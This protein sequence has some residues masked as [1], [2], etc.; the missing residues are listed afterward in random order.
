MDPLERE[1]LAQKAWIRQCEDLAALLDRMA[2]YREDLRL[3]TRSGNPLLQVRA[4]DLL[5]LAEDRLVELKATRIVAAQRE[6]AAARRSAEA[7]EQAKRVEVERAQEELRRREAEANA[8]AAA[9]AEARRQEEDRLA[10]VRQAREHRLAEE[11]ARRQEEARAA[12]EAEQHAATRLANARAA[13]V[14]ARAVLLRAKAAQIANS[15]E[16]G[17]VGVVAG[18]RLP[19]GQVA[20]VQ[21]MPNA[22]APARTEMRAAPS[23]PPSRSIQLAFAPPSWKPGPTTRSRIGAKRS[24]SW[25]NASPSQ[26]AA[27]TSTIASSTGRSHFT[28]LTPQAPRTGSE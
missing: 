13:E 2:C 24:T 18:M 23:R 27:P 4:S 20:Q 17:S 3:G 10:A 21:A 9:E 22:E 28:S 26:P 1:V 19:V 5:E 16:R 12:A 6:D 15:P 25:S 8:R 7:R 14:E 11:E